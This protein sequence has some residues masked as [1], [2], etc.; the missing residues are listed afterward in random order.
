VRLNSHPAAQYN[1]FCH[2]NGN[3][4]T[5]KRDEDWNAKILWKMRME[6]AYQWDL[7]EEEVSEVFEQLGKSV[8]TQLKDIKGR[9]EGML[10]TSLPSRIVWLTPRARVSC[11]GGFGL[12][13]SRGG[14]RVRDHGPR[15]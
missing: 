2:N 13:L 15:V 4:K 7:V 9:V 3:H 12:Q 6:L 10:A 1:A 14:D 8:T 11:L 5:P